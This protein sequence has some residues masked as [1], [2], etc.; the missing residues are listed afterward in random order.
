ML[1]ETAM[2]FKLAENGVG[3]KRDLHGKTYWLYWDLRHSCL[4]AESLA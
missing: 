1:N 4:E 3:M 2:M